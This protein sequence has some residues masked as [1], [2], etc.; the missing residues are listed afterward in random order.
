MQN[1]RLRQ[2]LLAS[3]LVTL[4]L[5][6][7]CASTGSGTRTTGTSERGWI[8]ASPVLQQQI[9]DEG[10]MAWDNYIRE[11][12]INPGAK[13]RAGFPNGMQS[14]DGQINEVEMRGLIAYMRSLS[15]RNPQSPIEGYDHLDEQAE[16]ATEEAEAAS[17]E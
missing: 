5:M 6:T 3:A 10:P 8:Q 17:G 2:T 13:I 16:E 4:P 15:D 14:F 7:G 9:D 12:V 11:S 1:Q